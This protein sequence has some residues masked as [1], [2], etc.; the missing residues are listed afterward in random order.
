MV[1]DN[2]QMTPAFGAMD[3]HAHDDDDPIVMMGHKYVVGRW[4]HVA[5]QRYELGSPLGICMTAS[6]RA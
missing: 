6:R 5:S 4:P 2:G 1:D 3:R